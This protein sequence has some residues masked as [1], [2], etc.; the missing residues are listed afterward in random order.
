MF[1]HSKLCTGLVLAFGG[2]VIAPHGAMA[3]E[4]L[5][6]V[7]ITGS[8]IKRI[9]AEGALPVMVMKAE[10]I[11]AS[12]VTSAADLVQRLT[13][14]QNSTTESSAVGGGSFGFTGISLHNIGETR[15]LVLINGKRMAQFGGQTLTG[16]AAGFDVNAI[17]LS[18]IERVELLTDGASALYGADA[19]AGVVN[20]ILKRNST[21][22][23]VTI[24]F[25]NPVGN[26]ATEKRI[27]ASMGYGS[28]EKDGFN[29]FLSLS[30][31]ERTQLFA[32]DR[33]YA[34]S[35][36]VKFEYGGKSYQKQQFSPSP[37]PANVLDDKDQL[38]SPYLL[39]NGKCPPRTFRVTEPYNDGSGLVDDYCGFD[40]VGELEIYP[41]RKRDSL[42]LS[43]VAKIGGQE[44]YANA[45]LAR[46]N[47]VSRIAPVPGGISIPAG[48]PLHDKYLKPLGITVD[49]TAFYRLYDLGKRSSNDT[50]EFSNL[51]FGTKGLLL[52][53]DYDASYS[54][55]S[56]KVEGSIGGYPGGLA[57]RTLRRS[58]LLDPFV[59]AGQQSAAGQAAINA[60]SYNGYFDGG[61]SKLSQYQLQGS[62]EIGQADGGPIMLGAGANFNQE[63]FES[64][65]SLFAQG[66]L[67][68]PVAGTLC[69]P[70]KGLPCD[71]R[72]GDA[73]AS[74][75][76][77]ADRTSKG[78]FGEVVVPL[79][80]KLEVGAAMRFDSYSDFGTATTAKANFR[81][82]PTSSLLF[83]GSVGTGFHA[84]TVPQVNATPRSYGVTTNKYLCTTELRT[85]AT[86]LGAVCQPG[87]KQYDVLA[88][89]NPNLKAEK[90]Q[91]GTLGF[92]FEPNN[93][94]SFGADLW[95]VAIKD[96]FGSLGEAT[97]M[98]APIKYKSGFT[99]QVDIAT[100]IKYVALNRGNLNLGDSFN[101]GIDFEV[102]GRMKTALGQLTSNVTVSQVIRSELGSIITGNYTSDI[103]Q[104]G[105]A[106]KTRAR[107]QTTLKTGSFSNTLGVSYQSGYVEDSETVDVLDAAGNVTGQEDIAMDIPAFYTLDWQTRWEPTKSWMLTGGVL[108]LTDKAPP[109]NIGTGGV[110][111]GQQFGYDDRYFDP[112]G[113]TVYLNV[114]YKF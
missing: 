24:G 100:G 56:S 51:V 73:S 109:L 108:N 82:S 95:G 25:S 29:A 86:E 13:T 44:V 54:Y 106:Q 32:T 40:F 76:Y 49:T 42:T 55:S 78:V 43:T 2:L 46:T 17:P 98:S 87:N 111:R 99:T 84:P 60:T 27:S 92:R 104:G 28:L 11:K 23:D 74:P 37:I 79:T 20:F 18:A 58:G 107:I 63:Y 103:G 8:S 88:A 39:K 35:G 77:S 102:T 53:W 112:R 110:G 90:S 21:D 4:T 65:P 114:S 7:E 72:F 69:D 19:I 66:K 113:R 57:I 45:L 9:A 94:I 62:R 36:K 96:S 41:E 12:G 6:R 3:Q 1:K 70:A 67:A 89:G 85:V 59:E 81:W 61:L 31:D 83:R 97:L 33:S 14:V 91:Q 80:K 22:G 71:Q 26:V 10:D 30:H 64:R 75:P 34:K 38:V 101:A 47:Q 48:S 93:S 68:D 52:G 50:S 105:G 16:F 15:T 5:E